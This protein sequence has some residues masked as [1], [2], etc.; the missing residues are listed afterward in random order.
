MCLQQHA[1]SGTSNHGMTHNQQNKGLAA[2]AAF[3]LQHR[4]V[5]VVA[6]PAS[7]CG[8]LLSLRGFSGLPG[9]TSACV[10]SHQL[11]ETLFEQQH[12][13]LAGKHR[14][15]K[16]K[17]PFVRKQQHLSYYESTARTAES[18]F[19]ASLDVEGLVPLTLFVYNW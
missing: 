16:H 15:E 13:E 7:H 10:S 9:M 11:G 5:D 14:K 12:C 8:C 6:S 3:K 2:E 19:C 1:Y 17:Q 4:P 18:P